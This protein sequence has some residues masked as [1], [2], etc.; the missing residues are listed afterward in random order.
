MDL[1]DEAPES[2][3]Q[4]SDIERGFP[5]MVRF[6]SFKAPFWFLAQATPLHTITQN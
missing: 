4:Q 5:S 1:D 6:L 2:E 3:D